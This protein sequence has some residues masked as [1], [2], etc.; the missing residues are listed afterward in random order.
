MRSDL[1]GEA[2]HFHTLLISDSVA[3]MLVA[4]VFDSQYRAYIKSMFCRDLPLY[5]KAYIANVAKKGFDSWRDSIIESINDLHDKN[6]WEF[7]STGKR[8]SFG[9]VRVANIKVAIKVARVL[10]EKMGNAHVACYHSNLFMMHRHLLECRLDL[11]LNRTNGNKHI[12]NDSEIADIINRSESKNIL[13]IV[14]ATPVEEIGRDHDFDWAVIEP[15]ST[16]AIVQPAGRVNRH[17]LKIMQTENIAI[18]RGNHK[19]C[20]GNK[21]SS[22]PVFTKPGLETADNI[23]PHDLLKLMPALTF[24]VDASLRFDGCEFARLDDVSLAEKMGTATDYFSESGKYFMSAHYKNNRLR[25]ENN[26]NVW[27]NIKGEFCLRKLYKDTFGRKHYT[28]TSYDSCVDKNRAKLSNAWLS[29]TVDELS[30]KCLE[31][32]VPV[33]RGMSVSIAYSQNA[34]E[35][36]FDLHYGFSL[37]D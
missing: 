17:R 36:N 32:N 18:L 3:P 27:A 24:P 19:V 7:A 5:R 25:D 10:A 22:E 31:L 14:V 2:N 9:L 35:I 34:L 15:S 21:K 16:Q 29:W 6:S 20:V 8:V 4:D 30:N 1:M 13:F 26:S 33:E 37:H 28:F 12:E 11:L 23:F